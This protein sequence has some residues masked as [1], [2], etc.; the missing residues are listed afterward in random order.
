VLTISEAA[1]NQMPLVRDLFR[2][3]AR[4][5]GVD[6][7]F[8]GFEEELR[9]LPG[10]YARP[11]GVVLL[12]EWEGEVAACGAIKPLEP[13]VAEVKRLYV[14]PAFR[15][16]GISRRLMEALLEEASSL[17]YRRVRLDT[18]ARLEP[19]LALYRSMEFQEIPPYNFN[20]EADIVYLERSIT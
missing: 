1:E 19:A 20:P 2:E 5:L 9:D 4:E 15:G 6:L 7:C 17:G 16:R 14:R 10:K 11:S 8:Q 13:E 12:A 3:Y 18:L